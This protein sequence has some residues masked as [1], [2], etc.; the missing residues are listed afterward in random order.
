[1]IDLPA[2]VPEQ[3]I[4]GFGAA[5]AGRVGV[6]ARSLDGRHE[7]NLEAD[8]VYPTASSIKIYVLYTLLVE[9]DRQRISL[10][11]RVELTGGSGYT[12]VAG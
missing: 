8:G 6:S 7:I 11:D 3:K 2:A 5:H 1:M 10:A 4:T 9:A 12:T